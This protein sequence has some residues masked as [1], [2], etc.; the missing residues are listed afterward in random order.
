M[1][2]CRDESTTKL[3]Y[4]MRCCLPVLL[5]LCGAPLPLGFP[6]PSL[7]SPSRTSSEFSLLIRCVP[8]SCFPHTAPLS[9]RS[10]CCPPVGSAFHHPALQSGDG[11]GSAPPRSVFDHSCDLRHKCTRL[12][13][14]KARGKPTSITGAWAPPRRLYQSARRPL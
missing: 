12:G 11:G 14:R 4:Y 1:K 5:E 10:V 13:G 3:M 8:P 6:P 7:A 9:R 2:K